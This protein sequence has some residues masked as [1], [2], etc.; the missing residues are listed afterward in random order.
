MLE[1]T[2]CYR[3]VTQSITYDEAAAYL[4]FLRGPLTDVFTYYDASNHVLFTALAR[5][6]SAVFGVSALRLPS[7]TAAAGFFVAIVA[8][9]RRLFGT[10][11]LALLAVAMVALNPFVLD[12]I[13]IPSSSATS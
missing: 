12:L 6:S 4:K 9:C 7:V 3:A 1:A 13:S 10:G 8:V 5:V 2:V 11:V